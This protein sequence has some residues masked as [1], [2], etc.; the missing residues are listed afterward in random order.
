MPRKRIRLLALGLIRD[1]DRILLSRGVDPA[2][3]Q[4]FYRALGGGVEFGETS[5]EALR[6]EFQEEIQAELVNVHYVACIE[7]LFTFNNHVRHEVIQLF[8]GDF[9]DPTFY[10]R[11]EIEFLEGRRRKLAL[12]V[13]LADCRAGKI[14]VVPD[15]FLSFIE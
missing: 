2:N 3:H 5:L 14:Q 7:N 13:N 8:Q 15:N 10:M 6:R 11:D 1:R 12:W 9:A 4:V